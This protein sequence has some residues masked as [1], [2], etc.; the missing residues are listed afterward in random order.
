MYK[1]LL[2]ED[3]TII[4]KGLL[5]KIQH[6]DL[7]ISQF[8][9]AEDS[10][11]ALDII[12]RVVPD[13]VITDIRLLNMDGLSMVEQIHQK[14]SGIKVI[15]ISGYPDFEYAQKAISLGVVSYLVKP[16][17]RDEL[18][19]ALQKCIQQ[20]ESR[21][22]DEQDKLLLQLQNRTLERNRQIDEILFGGAQP[23]DKETVQRLFPD[24]EGFALAAVSLTRDS[25]EKSKFSSD[26]M[27]LIRYALINVIHDVAFAESRSAFYHL[28][29]HS[30][31]LI[32]FDVRSCA[33][34][35]SIRAYC[36]R[37]IEIVREMLEITVNIYLSG[38]HKAPG[39][40]LIGETR[41][42]QEM[43]PI[44]RNGAVFCFS[45]SP[46]QDI[47][48][49]N[50]DLKY[51]RTCVARHPDQIPAAVE[52]IFGAVPAD[53]HVVYYYQQIF[54]RIADMAGELQ[55]ELH[56][57]E[58]TETELRQAAENIA[59]RFTSVRVM[60]DTVAQCLKE[61]AR[62]S[63]PEVE[64]IDNN[65]NRIVLA[66]QY[67]RR[68]YDEPISVNQLADMFSLNPNYF[69]TLFKKET[70]NTVITF[71]NSVRVERA[72]YL[73][74]TTAIS[75]AELSK[76]IGYEN[77]NYFYKLFKK[78][79]GVTPVEYRNQHRNKE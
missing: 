7:G 20:I 67:I 55:R 17:G 21:R 8:Y 23:A 36:V 43:K 40:A 64:G 35:G 75:A 71:L 12:D 49:E 3:E 60:R 33:S 46:R 44:E 26:D 14:Y 22:F 42:A 11:E 29:N 65:S 47:A 56:F 39:P 27:G 37:L 79:A 13:I 74:E 32:L 62:S 45:P 50:D 61:A 31:V 69:S 77:T 72:C 2:V 1:L 34:S 54:S 51:L 48:I 53:M 66:Q 68:H 9:E 73:L 70:G 6:H 59:E 30:Q 24:A 76:M 52:R 78:Y 10:I 28:Q 38:M 25:L 15:V 18:R 19:E 58:P 5:A 16:V 57:S 4:R 41:A 63:R